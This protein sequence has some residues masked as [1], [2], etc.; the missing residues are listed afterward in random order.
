MNWVPSIGSPVLGQIDWV[1]ANDMRGSSFHS[2]DLRYASRI[3]AALRGKNVSN[4]VC[5]S[6]KSVYN[7]WRL[8]IGD[9]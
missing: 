6:C 1:P 8:V 2:E 5:N 3:F 9:W 7:G 4:G